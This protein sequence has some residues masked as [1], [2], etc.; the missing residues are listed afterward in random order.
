MKIENAHKKIS[1]KQIEDFADRQGLT[2]P[3]SYK[4]FLLDTNGGE[5]MP[6]EFEVPNWLGESSMVQAFFGIHDGENN[7]LAA[8]ID[9]FKNRLPQGFVPIASDPA[10]N[11]LCLGTNGDDEGRIYFWDHEEELDDDGLSKKDFSN[12]YRIANNINE[13]LAELR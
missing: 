13:F 12:M 2:L 10:G 8:K 1:L 5:P 11:L 3:P 9:M 4:E 6:N 7:N